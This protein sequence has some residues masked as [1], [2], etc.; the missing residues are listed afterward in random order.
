MGLAKF[1]SIAVR[2]P[3]K[4][5]AKLFFSLRPLMITGGLSHFYSPNRS[6][7]NFDLYGF[8]GTRAKM[9]TQKRLAG[10]VASTEHTRWVR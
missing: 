6:F 2:K 10:R 5:G 4:V 1:V 8:D 9:V 7:K 3:K